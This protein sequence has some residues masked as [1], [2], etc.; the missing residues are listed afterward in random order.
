MRAVG[1]VGALI[2]RLERRVVSCLFVFAFPSYTLYPFI[3]SGNTQTAS[4]DVSEKLSVP[5]QTNEDDAARQ[6]AP[7][8]MVRFLTVEE[9]APLTT[10]S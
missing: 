2:Y 1:H 8:I 3:M 6:R 10:P 5:G 4:K 9:R 7:T